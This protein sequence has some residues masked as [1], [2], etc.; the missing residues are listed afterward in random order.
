MDFIDKKV[1]VVED[2]A[3]LRDIIISQLSKHYTVVPAADGEEAVQKLEKDR[4]D[5]IVLDLLLPKLDGFGVMEKIRSLPDKAL[6]KTPIIVVS[7]LNDE[8]SMAKANEF[9][10]EAYFTKADVSFGI[11]VNRIN[12]IVSNAGAYA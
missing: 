3:F 11:L 8:V 7:N 6:A 10:I 1:L 2:D 12:R 4:P 9:F 5:V